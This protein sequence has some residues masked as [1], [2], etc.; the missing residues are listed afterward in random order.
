MFSEISNHS[1]LYTMT[2]RQIKRLRQRITAI[3]KETAAHYNSENRSVVGTSCAYIPDDPNQSEGCA[4]GR[5][6]S[7]KAKKWIISRKL[8]GFAWYGLIC[9][10]KRDKINITPQCFK[11]FSAGFLNALQILHDSKEHWCENGIS[12]MGLEYVENLLQRIKNG[13]FDS[14]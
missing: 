14:K 8:N 4:I 6:L 10:A 9:E 7:K 5:K 11:N 2:N 1:K 13:T 3:V 12:S